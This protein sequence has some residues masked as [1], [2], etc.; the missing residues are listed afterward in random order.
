[1]CEFV[2]VFGCSKEY[3]QQFYDGFV[4]SCVVELVYCY[5]FGWGISFFEEF[6]K[7]FVIFSDQGFN[8]LVDVLVN[9]F[10]YV[11]VFGEE[12]V[13]YFWDFGMEV[14]ES[15]GWGFNCK[16]FNFSVLFD[17]VLQYVIFYV[18]YCQFFVDQYV[19]GGGNDLV[20]NK[21][22]VI[23]LSGIVLVVIWLVFYGYDSCW[24][25]VSNGL[26]SFG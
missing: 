5:F 18:F 16:F 21:F 4:N 1:M 17:G 24:L 13:F 26:N 8:G 15:V 6:C 11:Q 14:Q 19:Y 3:C 12:I 22:G 2:C 23:F 9:F 10:E 7:L 20:V 25:L